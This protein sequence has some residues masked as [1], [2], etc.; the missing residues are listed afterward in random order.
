MLYYQRKCETKITILLNFYRELNFYF[1]VFLE[2]F[3]KYFLF[4]KFLKSFQ[5]FVYIY[6]ANYFISKFFFFFHW[7]FSLISK[8]LHAFMLCFLL[9]STTAPHT[10]PNLPTLIYRQT[11]K[12][13]KKGKHEVLEQLCGYQVRWKAN[14][15]LYSSLI[16]WHKLSIDTKSSYKL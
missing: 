10:I 14:A 9:L 2:N 3:S 5:C 11:R 6:S 7:K 13:F 16:Y 4:S 12:V 15:I 1:K 8:F